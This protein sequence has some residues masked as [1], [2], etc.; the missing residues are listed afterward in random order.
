VAVEGHRRDPELPC[1]APQADR[2]EAFGGADLEGPGHDGLTRQA[3][4]SSRLHV[5]FGVA[6]L[7]RLTSNDG[8]MTGHHRL[9]AVR[10]H[11]LETPHD[12]AAARTDYRAAPSRQRCHSGPTSRTATSTNHNYIEGEV[13]MDLDRD[14]V[15]RLLTTTRAVRRRLDLTRPVM[16][17]VVTECL[18]LALQ[19]PTPADQQNWHWVVV[20]DPVLRSQ[21]GEQYRAA[22]EAFVRGQLD[23]LEPGGDRRRMESVLHLVEHLG[24]V[25]VLVA[26]YV[27][28]PGLGLED[29]QVPPVLLY[30]SVFPAVWSFQ[31]AL[32]SRGLGT[33]PL[34]MPDE[35]ALAEVLGVPDRAHLAALLPVA[36]YTGDSFRRASRLPVVDVV[37]WDSWDGPDP[38][39]GS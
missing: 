20:T 37:G 17:D 9:D 39:R 30:G 26:A 23:E 22:N 24:E 18:E 2:L 25:P 38:G 6:V 29:Q 4:P 3:R 14:T 27:V 5:L 31:L 16:P 28:E 19:A 10:A 36:Y 15:D 1:E 34:F 12:L 21:I 32:R 13:L 8:R 35:A 11:L 33:V 7:H